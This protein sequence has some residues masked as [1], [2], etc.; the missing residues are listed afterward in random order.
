MGEWDGRDVNRE[1]WSVRSDK[2]TDGWSGG[3]SKWYT[4]C[5]IIHTFRPPFLLLSFSCPVTLL[6]HWLV[7]VQESVWRG[8]EDF[9]SP[10]LT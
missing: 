7:E 1:L 5:G 10:N 6:K 2:T 9:S 3:W 4:D 8:P